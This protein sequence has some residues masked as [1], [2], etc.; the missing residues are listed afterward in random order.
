M[1]NKEAH[2]PRPEQ[3]DGATPKRKRPHDKLLSLYPMTEDEALRQLLDAG[4]LPGKQHTKKT[5]HHYGGA[6]TW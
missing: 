3:P 1:A 4:P 6:T 2:A 5:A